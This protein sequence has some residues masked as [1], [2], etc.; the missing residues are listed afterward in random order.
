MSQVSQ[1]KQ[2]KHD[3]LLHFPGYVPAQN[4]EK[5]SESAVLSNTRQ[6]DLSALVHAMATGLMIGI[7]AGL[8][9]GCFL[10][11]LWISPETT[12]LS[13]INYYSFWALI[14]ASFGIAVFG[15]QSLKAQQV[16]QELESVKLWVMGTGEL[17]ELPKVR[18]SRKERQARLE[19]RM[20][21]REH[22]HL[23]A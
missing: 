10:E 22:G 2:H 19:Q 7:P 21:L 1:I 5:I 13:L 11:T 9:W 20:E 15:P 4:A 16:D 17:P 8:L 12:S 6:F 18:L 23:A 3:N 14:G